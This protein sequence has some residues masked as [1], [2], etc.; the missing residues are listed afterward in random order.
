M[1]R[2]R[3]V[4]VLGMHRS[5]TSVVARG[6]EVLGIRLGDNLYP[7]AADNPKG[8]W[9]D[10]DFLGINEEL[11]A[12]IGSGSERLGLL[13]WNLP[14][15]TEIASIGDRGEKI[16][17][18]KCAQYASWGFK[19]P[20]TARLLPFWQPIFERVGCDVCYVIAMRNPLSVVQSLFKR[21]GL[22][23]AKS[24]YLWLEHLLPAI[25]KT[26]ASKRV[27]VDYDRLLE[28][29]EAQLARIALMLGFAAPESLSLA[30]YEKE[31]LESGLRHARYTRQDLERTVNVPT[32]VIAAYELLVTLA[33]SNGDS[34]D[35]GIQPVFDVLIDQLKSSAPG[36]WSATLEDQVSAIK[37]RERINSERD[38]AIR[39]QA[40]LIE[41][42][43]TGMSTMEKMI[44]ER[45][46]TILAQTRLI[47]DGMAGMSAMEQIIR[48][49]DETIREQ[50][51]R[52]DDVLVR[53]RDLQK[54]IGK[55]DEALSGKELET[56][57]LKGN[58]FVRV[59]MFLRL[60]R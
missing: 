39:A 12:C 60:I 37:I 28:S 59:L 8:F 57:R 3:V 40:K 34:D 10:R 13:D 23:K 48:E 43:M 58:I 27:V 24:F 38:A 31:F 20:R 35:A 47:D 22:G 41:D 16:I 6:L 1:D 7:P 42:G 49:R 36:Y 46:E 26:T 53:I 11:L 17:R 56:N 52:F 29:P 15:S 50:A 33:N 4:V 19:D 14:E 9:E 25:S 32:Q 45:D 54:T 51:K 30:A 21:N 18:E 55:Y 5:G 2:S 44:R